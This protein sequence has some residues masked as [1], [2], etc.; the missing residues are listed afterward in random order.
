[1][2][3]WTWLRAT[4]ACAALACGGS[5]SSG[6]GAP[7]KGFYISITNLAYA[8]LNLEVPPG[9][10]VTVINND[11]MQHSVTSEAASGAFTLGAVAG[12]SF[13]TQPFVGTATFTVPTGA[14]NGT[15]VPYF[16]TVHKGTMATPNAT[17]TVNSSA[18]PTTAP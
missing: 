4:M 14:A 17:I 13:D 10:T 8:P 3:K 12:I 6:G 1:M 18:Q 5:S 11:G 9:A 7:P 2:S 15:V 16:C